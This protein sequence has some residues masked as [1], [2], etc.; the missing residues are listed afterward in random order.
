[1]ERRIYEHPSRQSDISGHFL[2]LPAR[3][4]IYFEAGRV[5][6]ARVAHRCVDAAAIV[7]Q[8][9]GGFECPEVER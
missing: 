3:T 9:A 8:E 2:E 7:G 4:Q 1:M 5:S 6:A